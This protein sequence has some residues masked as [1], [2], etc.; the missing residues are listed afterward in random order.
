MFGEVKFLALQ[1]PL[2]L[3]VSMMTGKNVTEIINMEVHER[4]V[5]VD[6]VVGEVKDV[7]AAGVAATDPAGPGGV[8]LTEEELATIIDEAGD[9]KDVARELVNYRA[10]G[11]D[12]GATGQ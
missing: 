1:Q 9:V 11:A 2:I 5:L 7:T 12:G 6:R 3:L 4:M 8:T 10:G